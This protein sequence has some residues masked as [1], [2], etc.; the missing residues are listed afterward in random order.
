MHEKTSIADRKGERMTPGEKAQ[1][2]RARET[3]RRWQ[4]SAN[5]KRGSSRARMDSRKQSNINERRKRERE[6]EKTANR[7]VKNEVDGP[8]T[9]ITASV[10][11]A[12]CS[13]STP[14]LPPR[15]QP[16]LR[17]RSE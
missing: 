7:G 15:S 1:R 5:N 12:P 4:R 9:G 14:Q 10:A 6:R 13:F 16:R 8:E 2:Q 3:T 17:M 11:A